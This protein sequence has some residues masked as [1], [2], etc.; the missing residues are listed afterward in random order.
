M[1]R[2]MFLYPITMQPCLWQR[3]WQEVLSSDHKRQAHLHWTHGCDLKDERAIWQDLAL[4]NRGA[5]QFGATVGAVD[6]HGV[7]LRKS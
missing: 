2:A 7:M 6:G 5:V 3:T 1:C 4:K